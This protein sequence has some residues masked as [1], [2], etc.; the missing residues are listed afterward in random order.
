MQDPSKEQLIEMIVRLRR[1]GATIADILA[2]V[3]QALDQPVD[4][5][6]PT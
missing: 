3:G 6:A 4:K 1:G 5:P 2:A